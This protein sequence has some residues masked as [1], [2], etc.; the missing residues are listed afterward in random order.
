MKTKTIRAAL[1]AS[2]LSCLPFAHAV[3]D[4]WSAPQAPFKV[5][6]NTWYVGTHG[7]SSLLITSPEGHIL[8]DGGI[9]EAAPQIL[10]HIRELG[11]DP[12]DVRYILNSHEHFDH[13]GGI[14]AL[15]RATGAVVLGSVKS[16]PVLRTGRQDKG[17]PQYEDGM[18]PQQ[19]IAN[20]RVVRDGDVVKVGPLALTAHYT[21]GHTQG[22]ISW[23]WRETLDGRTVSMVYADSLT[24]LA[25]GSFRYTGDKRYPTARADVEKSIATIAGFDCDIL[26]TPHPEASDLWGRKEKGDFV[27][28]NACRAYAEKGRARLQE[29]LEKEAKGG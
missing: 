13:A 11:F 6:G 7:L 4:H 20:T 21:P 26:V 16:E 23:T 14:P 27:D 10:A 9:P 29:I 25:A 18:P 5:A 8:V 12:K 28:G 15:W 24:P 1:L 22:G 19:P 2:A 17:D 3:P